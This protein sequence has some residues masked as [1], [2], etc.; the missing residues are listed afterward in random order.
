MT[1]IETSAHHYEPGTKHQSI[2]YH[3]KV[4]PLKI[5]QKQGLGSKT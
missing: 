4:S 1:A 2:E 5:I 3:Q